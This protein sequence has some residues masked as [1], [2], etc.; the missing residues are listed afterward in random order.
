[1]TPSAGSSSSALTRRPLASPR[2]GLSC[3]VAVNEEGMLAFQAAV[4]AA[5]KAAREM[6]RAE[7][8]ASREVRATLLQPL[9]SKTPRLLAA[10]A[11]ASEG[12]LHYSAGTF[13]SYS[14]DR[15]SLWFL[16][17]DGRTYAL[18]V[19]I[20]S[21]L[22][23]AWQLY[24]HHEPAGGLFQWLTWDEIGAPAKFLTKC[25][26]ELISCYPAGVEPARD[27]D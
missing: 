9:A 18:H 5:L 12:T 3:E 4:R 2:L 27:W 13:G 21:D 25:V 14:N 15:Y 20:V 17:P 8:R 6:Y 19:M 7:E 11:E 24:G 26:M 16:R 1:M 22:R 10:A 23:A